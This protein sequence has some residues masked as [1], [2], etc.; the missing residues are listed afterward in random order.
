MDQEE[1]GHVS[2]PAQRLRLFDA[3]RFVGEVSARADDRP[4]DALE[5]ELVKRG[6][7][8]QCPHARIAR[9][10]TL[11]ELARVSVLGYE[12]DGRLGRGECVGFLGSDVTASAQ[13]F[14]AGKHHRKWLRLAPLAL[15]Q[16]RDRVKVGRIH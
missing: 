1:I 9:R 16:T 5:Q 3:H 2:E 8:Q 14:E 7:G 4:V 15:P 11:G 13:H 10:D 6:I 12:Q